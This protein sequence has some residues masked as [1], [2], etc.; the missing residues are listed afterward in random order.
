M[1]KIDFVLLW[2]DGND[3]KWLEEKNKYSGH[4]KDVSNQNNRYRD[5]DLLKYWFRGVEKYAP[6]V[7]KIHFVTYGHL[8]EWLNT[9]NE[10]I[11]I[12]KHSDFIPEEYLPTFNSN[13]IQYYLNRIPGIT[14]KFVMFDDDQFII[15]EVKETDFFKNDKICDE[16][17]ERVIYASKKGDVY[18]HSLLNNMQIVNTYYKKR[19]VYRK[20]LLKFFS[21]KNG[22]DNL[23]CSALSLR[24]SFFTG[25][26]NPH[27]CQAY[28]KKHYDLFWRYGEEQLEECSKNKFRKTTDLTTFLIRYIE[29]MEGDFI[30]RSH[31][32]GKRVELGSNN[33]KIYKYIEERKYHV[34]CINDSNMDINFNKTQ[35]ELV[36]CF[37]KILPEKSLFEREL[38]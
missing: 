14:D 37:E 16:Y 5:W 8:P 31:R 1:E 18:P 22:L 10:K 13:V 32:F 15:K 34:L 2:V 36:N 28:T 4:R 17:G 38:S 33:D 9:D 21:Y 19:A 11:N 30:P 35:K 25:F 3:E 26:Y 27:I 6:W 23:L 20:N 12:V 24:Y 7:N 29:I